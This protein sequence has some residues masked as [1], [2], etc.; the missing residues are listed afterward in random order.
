LWNIEV[1]HAKLLHDDIHE[2]GLAQSEKQSFGIVG[3]F[4]FG[5]LSENRIHE[6][7]LGLVDLTQAPVMPSIGGTIQWPQLR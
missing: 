2:T 4:M 5:S 3:V 7:H 6:L 1:R